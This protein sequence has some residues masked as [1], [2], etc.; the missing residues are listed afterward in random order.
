[1]ALPEPVR[2]RELELLNDWRQEAQPLEAS[3]VLPSFPVTSL[4]YSDGI[5]FH[6]NQDGWGG[7][8]HYAARHTMDVLNEWRAPYTPDLIVPR[9]AAEIERRLHTVQP[10]ARI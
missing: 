9:I 6:R 3:R 4:D 5:M 10:P 7:C 1:M 2:R 8:F